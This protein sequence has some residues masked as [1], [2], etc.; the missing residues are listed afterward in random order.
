VLRKTV[1]PLIL[2]FI[3]ALQPVA[4]AVAEDAPPE[5]GSIGATLIVPT[6]GSARVVVD[7]PTIIGDGA[8]AINTDGVAVVITP[9]AFSLTISNAL[10]ELVLPMT[11][12]DGQDVESFSDPDTGISIEGDDIVIPLRNEAG[13]DVLY[14]K[15]TKDGVDN[16]GTE[17]TFALQNVMLSSKELTPDFSSDDEDV[18]T[19]GVSFEVELKALPEG[20]IV[21]TK[22]T[23]DANPDCRN[24]FEVAL[25]NEEQKS[26][27][28][29]A[30]VLH[31]IKTNLDNGTHLGGA[32]ITMKVGR[33]WAEA[34]GYDNIAILRCGEGEDGEQRLEAVYVGDDGDNAVFEAESPVGLSYFGLVALGAE[35]GGNL[36]YILGGVGGA[37]LVSGVLIFFILRRRRIRDSM[38]TS[39]WPTGLR[40]EDWKDP[41]LK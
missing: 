16:V 36:W 10:D 30:Y 35:Q 17:S 27:L 19:I 34:Y 9:G 40:P 38:L 26:I 14:I 13:L 11:L 41:D 25:R 37:V 20:V 15:A 7:I 22:V 1:L 28:N 5:E 39:S 12:P 31:V 4:Y 6:G 3:L 18:G 29:V 8:V 32:T 2:G 21:E 23:K 24:S 33:T